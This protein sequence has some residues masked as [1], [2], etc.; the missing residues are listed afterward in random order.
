MVF[1]NLQLQYVTAPLA[2]SPLYP[3][4]RVS[5]I[6]SRCVIIKQPTG[7]IPDL[8]DYS[9]SP[10]VVQVGN[11]PD[12][13][14]RY[15]IAS[16]RIIVRQSGV[17]LGGASAVVDPFSG[18]A[19]LEKFKL[20]RSVGLSSVTYD[21]VSNGVV[22]TR[23]AARRAPLLLEGNSVKISAVPA[24]ALVDPVYLSSGPI[25]RVTVGLQSI[26][27]DYRILDAN[28]A[29]LVGIDVRIKVL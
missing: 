19:S 8:S 21:I 14:Y 22:C 1:N 15:V 26:S 10:F 3:F 24:A 17:I 28:D 2:G 9:S 23:A 12:L 16:V 18:L 25:R 20:I 4:Y 13:P 5:N 11:R 29:E 27:I 6:V 7:S